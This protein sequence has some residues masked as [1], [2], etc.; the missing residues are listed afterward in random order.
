MRETND[1][2]PDTVIKRELYEAHI[3]GKYNVLGIFDDRPSVCRMWRED[4]GL[5]VLQAGDPHFEF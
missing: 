3:K 1:N 2:R 5:K 4:L